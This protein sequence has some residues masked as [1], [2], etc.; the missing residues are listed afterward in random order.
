MLIFNTKI[1][2]WFKVVF[3]PKLTIFP[4]PFSQ[5]VYVCVHENM[6]AFFDFNVHF[7]I[8]VY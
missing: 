5:K 3:F 1:S 2:Q 6:M 8:H 4:F 7:L